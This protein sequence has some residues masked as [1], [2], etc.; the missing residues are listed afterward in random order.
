MRD[1][2]PEQGINSVIQDSRGFIWLATYSG[3]SKFDGYSFTNYRNNPASS[4]SLRSNFVTSLVED[5]KGRLWI[6]HS[7]GIDLFD[8]R[9]EK[10]YLHWPDSGDR[11]NVSGGGLRK[12]SDGKIWICTPQGVFVAD[13]ETLTVAKFPQIS[14]P[15]SDIAQ[16]KDGSVISV[17]WEFGVYYVDAKTGQT[18]QYTHDPRNPKSISDPYSLSV[19]V[20]H[21]DRIWVGTKTGLELFNPQEKSFTRYPT[22]REVIRIQEDA[23]G[24]IWLG[25]GDGLYLFEPESGK[26]DKLTSDPHV[27]AMTRDKQG[28]VWASTFQGLRQLTSKHKKFNIYRQF[29]TYIG[30]IA[31]DRNNALWIMGCWDHESGM[32]VFKSS[33]SFEPVYHRN[34]PDHR[35][36]V[37]SLFLDMQGNVWLAAPW[38]L[39]RYNSANQTFHVVDIERTPSQLFPIAT[40]MDSNGVIWAGSWNGLGKYE[41][42]TGSVEWLPSFPVST[43]Y[44]IL[45]DSSQNLW[46]GSSAGLTRY[47]LG[48]GKLDVFNNKSND[49][50]SLSSST[51]YHLMMD[52]D[53]NIWVGTAGG[54]NKMIKGTENDVPRFLNWR[55][56]QSAL[57]NDDVYCIVDGGDGTLWMTCGNMISHFYPKENRFRNYDTNDGL[58][59]TNFRGI[60][61]LSGKGL[62]SDNGN[63]IFGSQDGLVVFHPDS[64]EDN[65]FIP[66]V[67]ISN[68]SIRNQTVPVTGTDADT[69]AWKTPL[70]HAISY[71]DKIRLT[72]DQNDFNLEFAALNFVN[73]ARNQYKYKLEAY[74]KEWTTVNASNRFAR[75][76]NISP[77]KYT[78][79]VIAT[80]NDGVWNEQ[81]AALVIIITPPWWQTWWAYLLYAIACVGLLVAARKNIIHRER[82]ASK[83]KLEHIELKKAQEIDR[84]KTDF[85]ANISHEFRTPITLILGPLKDLYGEANNDAQKKRLIT[86]MRNGERLLRLINQLLDLSKLEAG[87]MTLQAT[88]TDLVE[89]LKEIASNYESLATNKKIKF[90]F[91]PEARELPIYLD[92]EKMDKVLHNLLSNAFKFTNEGG[93]VILNLKS[94]EKHGVIIVKD[95]GIGIPS[96]Q[97]SKIFD[98]FYQI[99]SSKTRGYEG[100]GVGMAIAKE[101]VELHHGTI[102]VESKEGQGSTFTV[103]LRLGKEHLR[104]EEIIAASE[105]G[106]T[107]VDSVDFKV[108]ENAAVDDNENENTSS[109][110]DHQPVLLVVEDNSDMRH[111]IGKA[112]SGQ[113]HIIEAEN[114]MSGAAIAKESVPDLIISD[115]MMPGMNG[116]K[117]CYTI[118]TNELTSH[119]PVIL[120]TARA[121]RESKLAGLEIGADDYLSKP[122]DAD[123][124][125]L[126][127][128]NRIEERRKLRDRFSK[129]ITLEPKQISITSLDEKFIT[130]VLAIIEEHMDDE[131]FSVDDL[132]REGGYSNMHFYRKIK[133][134]SGQTPSH[135]LRTIRLKRAAELLSKD[136]DNV[137][138]IAYSVGFSSV[139]YFTKSF[140]AQFGVT[141]G[142]FAASNRSTTQTP[143]FQA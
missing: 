61:Y 27:A 65:K 102:T 24:E 30:H 31:K 52:S 62:R 35:E 122:F 17:G 66:P 28:I 98:R 96:D 97:V 23:T 132:S 45:E 6:G 26:M 109:L 67:V 128:R 103:Q 104:K 120:L 127:V 56:T 15:T 105:V 115:I 72:Y 79:R 25:C 124:L 64:L 10:F 36:W 55:T 112:L 113:F 20:D 100:T 138:Q 5:N 12:R 14:T 39:E 141:P 22:K 42:I 44:S 43:V 101:L 7:Q 57:P 82:L 4:N 86:M 58:T 54:L 126:I 131:T 49:P 114:G 110:A 63:I 121:D 11:Q 123:E 139:S 74:E 76:T 81:G 78:F 140:K 143:P 90:I 94:T 50:H 33:P 2:L 137:T 83:L 48:T 80:N 125:K 69:L 116:Y 88:Q 133:A 32:F 92:R 29:G 87:K 70:T 51:V 19:M 59:G 38:K 108:M 1:G 71:T 34:F 134:L 37:R 142:Q 136:S 75:Y 47:N 46:V 21:L 68:F 13:P 130:K 3:L 9:T 41:P 118:K 91:Y 135:F 107:N 93:Q 129:E 95:N 99:D 117:L 85:F 84:V 60:A 111:Y 40:F 119:I 89:F 53:R 18:A 8:P 106:K 73:P 77:G 16:T